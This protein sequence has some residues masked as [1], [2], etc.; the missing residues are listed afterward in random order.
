MTGLWQWLWDVWQVLVSIAS[1]FD[2][3]PLWATVNDWSMLGLLW[4]G[5]PIQIVFCVL[6]ATRKWRKYTFSRALMWKST[7]LAVYMY[8]GACK[9][10]VAGL[11]GFDW[12][13][14]IDLQTPIIN[15]YVFWAIV[16]QLRAITVEIIAGDPD[17][18][19]TEV[20]DKETP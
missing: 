12:P 13:W 15:A 10:S 9:V 6:Y 4:V 14:W 7:S 19:E 2:S 5:T 16:N 3:S 11:R 8:A 20:H 18:A 1:W 17:S